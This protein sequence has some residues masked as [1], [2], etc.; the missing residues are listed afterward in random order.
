MVLALSG[1]SD[2]ETAMLVGSDTENCM[3]RFVAKAGVFIGFNPYMYPAF[4]NEQLTDVLV[5]HEM[6]PQPMVGGRLDRTAVVVGDHQAGEVGDNGRGQAV[7]ILGCQQAGP[8]L[9]PFPAFLLLEQTQVGF[10]FDA[11]QARGC[12]RGVRHH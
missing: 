11:I 7:V 2:C 4:A 3:R 6:Q 12:G 1:G 8:R 10:Q 5:A 9:F